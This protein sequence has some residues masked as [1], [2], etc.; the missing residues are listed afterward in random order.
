[1]YN[2]YPIYII[3][4]KLIQINLK[5]VLKA[6]VNGVVLYSNTVTVALLGAE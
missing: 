5:A 2:N 1:M 4:I 6:A 3:N